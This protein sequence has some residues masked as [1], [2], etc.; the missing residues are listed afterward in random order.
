[1]KKITLMLS[2]FIASFILQ[3]CS[4]NEIKSDA[5]G[6]FEATET[7][8]SAEGTGKL[9]SL[10]V[11]EGLTLEE[12]M[13]VGFIDTVQ[14]FLKKKQIYSQKK[15]IGTKFGNINSQ[16]EVY[17]EQMRTAQ[18]EKNRI[19]NLIKDNAAS[20][21][22]LDDINGSLNTLQ[23]QVEM[24]MTQNNTVKSEFGNYD[25]QV[26]QIDD[27][28]EKS[29][30]KN[31]VR[32][33]VLMKLAEPGEIM[34]FGKPL[35]KIADLSFLNLRVFVSGEQLPKIKIGQKV[36]VLIDDG[37]EGFRELEGTISWISSKSEF[38]PK[39]IQTKEERV[40]LVYAVKIKVSNDGSLKIGM[41]GEVIFN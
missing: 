41:P 32:G 9:L 14:L 1:M 28:I 23:K 24:V 13:Q 6:N 8:V 33:T 36:K 22:Q 38:T 15:I 40:N 3:S 17:R 20:Q 21:K 37:K 31:P 30:I 25:V 2:I 5:F 12:G 16:A 26:Q 29:I 19:E 4:D 10:N 18:V 34:N 7:I 35:Y 11:E 39:I 27:Q